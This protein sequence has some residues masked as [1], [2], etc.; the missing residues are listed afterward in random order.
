LATGGDDMPVVAFLLLAM[1]LAQRRQPFASGVVLG[2]VSAMKFTAWPLAAL[3]LFAARNH[4]GQR[5]PG[6]MF[7]GM[8]VVA[9]PVVV[10][11]ALRGPWAFFDNVVLF[12]LG[13]SGVTSP[14][15]S[16]LPGHLIVTACPFLHRALPV[17]VGLIGGLLLALYL[18]RRPPQTVSQ[19]CNVGGVVMAIVTLFAPATR[20]G[21]LLYPINFFVWAY[22]FKE[23]SRREDLDDV[24]G[25]Q[26]PKED[27]LVT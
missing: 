14:A 22:L 11:F 24:H 5:R 8:L 25:V 23:P 3:A 17:G 4:R 1:V 10:P 16:P 27:V 2:I 9:G 7:L 19:V 6:V 13:L 20:I 12:P 26:R 15:A 18:Y 21:Y